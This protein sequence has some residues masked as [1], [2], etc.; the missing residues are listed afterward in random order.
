MWITLNEPWVAAWLGYGTGQHAPGRK[1]DAEAL[2][3]SHHQLLA[4][5]LAV[6][7]LR[8]SG[9]GSVG[10][11]L[12]LGPVHPASDS[13]DDARAAQL[14]DAHINRLFLDPLFAR[15]YP[16]ELMEHYAKVSDFGFVKQGDPELV[17][18]SLD[19][20]GV[21]YYSRHTVSAQPP[22]EHRS[23]MFAGNLATWG[24]LP[25]GVATTAMGWGIEPHGLTELLLRL[26]RDYPRIP[27]HVTENGAAFH[28]YVDPEGDVHDPERIAFLSDHLAAARAAMAAGVDL[29][30]YFAWSLLDNFE[31]A[32]GYS[33]RFGLVYVDY[34]TG[35]RTP[36]DSAAWYASMIA[37]D[38]RVGLTRMDAGGSNTLTEQ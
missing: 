5:G 6:D 27:I 23:S 28:D 18:R 4:H 13:P 22:P 19:F 32:E 36:K 8:A 7:A 21:N 20:L 25:V 35:R 37:G 3:A 14:T 26:H 29:R 9:A 38:R 11:T 24:V 15:G 31:W 12:N 33:K 10:I 16:L 17:S 30:G 34:L 1:D 2:A